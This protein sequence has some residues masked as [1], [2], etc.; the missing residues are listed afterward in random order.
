MRNRSGC[1]SLFHQVILTVLILCFLAIGT[2]AR[3]QVIRQQAIAERIA[4]V[5]ARPNQ[6]RQENPVVHDQPAKGLHQRATNSVHQ[7]PPAAPRRPTV[8]NRSQSNLAPLA[9]PNRPPPQP[10]ARQP[11]AGLPATLQP[12]LIIHRDLTIWS[13]R[14]P[15]C[16]VLSRTLV[17]LK[18]FKPNCKR[19]ASR[20]L[21]W[22]TRMPPARPIKWL[23]TKTKTKRIRRM[24][25]TRIQT[26]ITC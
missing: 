14:L 2:R 10:P 8:R 16:I 15:F 4:V 11:A 22:R 7:P 5:E 20:R 13:V 23:K 12:N 1:S 18:T 26:R 3:N 21:I 25:R 19:Q 17:Q 24:I 9:N 6:V